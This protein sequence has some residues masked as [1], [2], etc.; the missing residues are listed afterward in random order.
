M[1]VLVMQCT[2]QYEKSPCVAIGAG[3]A[4]YDGLPPGN[5][6]TGCQETPAFM[7]QCCYEYSAKIRKK[8]ACDSLSCNSVKLL[9]K[10]I[11]QSLP[12]DKPKLRY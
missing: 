4:Q 9:I 5:I 1:C 10:S 12:M 11:L 7:S 2:W 8:V 6:K 3:Y